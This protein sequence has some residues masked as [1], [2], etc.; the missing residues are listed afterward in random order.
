[1]VRYLKAIKSCQKAMLLLARQVKQYWMHCT[2]TVLICQ[3]QISIF[4]AIIAVDVAF[5]FF[6]SGYSRKVGFLLIS[7]DIPS[8]FYSQCVHVSCRVSV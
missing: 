1:M 4:T 6:L 5:F 2:Y 8:C 3:T 7:R